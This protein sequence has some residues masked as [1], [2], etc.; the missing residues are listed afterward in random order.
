MT[1]R[2]ATDVMLDHLDLEG[3]RVIDVGSGEGGLVRWLRGQGADA[4]GVECGEVMRERAVAA[5]PD[6]PE[7]HV[8]GVGQ[9]LPFDDG[10]ADVVVFSYSLHHVPGDAMRT[11]LEEAH[12][13]L[14]PGGRLFVLEP[15]AGGPNF[16]VNKLIDDETEVR[17]LAQ[18][19]LDDAP[20]IG[21]ELLASDGFDAS[22]V[23]ADFAA[24]EHR[25]V[26]VDPSRADAI[27]D[28]RD[29]LERRFAHFGTRVDDGIAFIQPNVFR[30]L[31]RPA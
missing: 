17:A 30:V 18:A 12:R 19:A 27:D 5:D 22:T 21:F 2:R 10:T 23:Y 16:E 7:A 31:Q 13:V 11:A 6:H 20:G 14:K 28:H 9:D 8:D 25:M 26:G 15:V 29:E 4:V 3:S 24:W 1:Q